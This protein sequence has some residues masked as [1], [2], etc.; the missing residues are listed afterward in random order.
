[1]E[2][3]TRGLLLLAVLFV[4][5]QCVTTQASAAGSNT[6]DAEITSRFEQAA[7]TFEQARAGSAAA[8]GPAQAAFKQL[9][10]QD[11]TNPLFMAYYGTT[12]AMQ[13]RDG[14]LPW[15]KIK[16][17]NQ[18][19]GY[20]DKALS[21]LGPQHDT[22]QLRG[23]PVSLETRL[24]AIAT[25]VSLPSFFKRMPAAKQQLATAMSSPLFA[26]A[27][28]ELRGRFYYEDALIA[29]EEGD[30]ERERRSLRVVVQYAPP[31][32]N[33]NEVR[34]QLAKLGG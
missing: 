6:P 8:V 1:M 3:R 5:C 10:D 21:L 28:A 19:V 34:E 4:S 29:H 7:H 11:A 27:S 13:A 26:T 23:V 2:L 24:V 33:M 9:L 31:S 16:L 12:F 14:G 30:K 25:F 17:V 20:I 22:E 15:Q 32:L 18:G